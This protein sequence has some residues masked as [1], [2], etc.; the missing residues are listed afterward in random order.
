MGIQDWKGAA[1]G[2]VA[3]A[4]PCC[5]AFNALIFVPRSAAILDA[6]S[7]WTEKLKMGSKAR[8]G[9]YEAEAESETSVACYL[10]KLRV[11]ATSG[12]ADE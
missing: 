9:R 3:L 7:P 1:P 11:E 8:F 5:E 4:C 6:T 10:I 12:Q 2:Y